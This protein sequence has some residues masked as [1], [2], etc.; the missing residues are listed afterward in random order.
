MFGTNLYNRHTKMRLMGLYS[1]K[2]IWERGTTLYT[3]WQKN[4]AS[5]GDCYPKKYGKRYAIFLK[6]IMRYFPKS[7]SCLLSKKIKATYFYS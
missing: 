6:P 7:N 5:C 3:R 2:S 1:I 4:R